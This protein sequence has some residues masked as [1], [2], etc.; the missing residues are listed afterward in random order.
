MT[1]DAGPAF[2]VHGHEDIEGVLWVF[3][4][5]APLILPPLAIFWA[6]RFDYPQWSFFPYDNL[7]ALSRLGLRWPNQD[8]FPIK[9]DYVH[10]RQ[11]RV[12]VELHLGLSANF[13]RPSFMAD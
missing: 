7:F 5:L 2:L 10:V 9:L 4:W 6:F 12:L 11:K 1:P 3:L 13:T 8:L